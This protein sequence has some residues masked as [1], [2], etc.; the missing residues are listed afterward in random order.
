MNDLARELG[1]AL[2]IA[3]LG[4]VLQSGISERHGLDRTGGPCCRAGSFVTR[5]RSQLGP[6]VKHQAEVAFTNGMEVAFLCAAVIV[7][8]TAAIVAGLQ[9]SHPLG[10]RSP[11]QVGQ[12]GRP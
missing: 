8:I 3:V 4:S 11:A 12:A 1:G 10:R 9:R 5:D 2:G 7:A 6:A